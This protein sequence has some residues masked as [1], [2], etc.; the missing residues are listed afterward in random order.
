[1]IYEVTLSIDSCSELVV[2]VEFDDEYSP[3]DSEIQEKAEQELIAE[4]ENSKLACW[5]HSSRR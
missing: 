2:E 4:I 3:S 1:M 5:R